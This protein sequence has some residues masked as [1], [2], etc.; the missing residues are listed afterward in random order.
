MGIRY[1]IPSQPNLNPYSQPIIKSPYQPIL[2]THY[3]LAPNPSLPPSI[4]QPFNP[5][6]LTHPPSHPPPLNQPPLTHP[7]SINPLSPTPSH[8]S[9]HPPSLTHPSGSLVGF[10][11]AFGFVMMTPQ[12]YINYKLKSVAHI[13]WKVS[14]QA[15]HTLSLH[16]LPPYRV[17][18]SS[19]HFLSP[20]NLLTY[21]N[22]HSVL[23][24]PYSHLI[25]S[26][27]SGDGI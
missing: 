17:L 23:D 20:F 21:S 26:V 7:L 4:T 16:S 24:A 8:P 1:R 27:V 18:A 13:P 14:N 3:P 5:P 19:I 25:C 15:K 2:S 9:S 22:P 10:V 11:Y 6:S 12:L